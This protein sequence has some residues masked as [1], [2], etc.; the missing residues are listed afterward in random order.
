MKLSV[1]RRQGQPLVAYIILTQAECT[2]GE[3]RGCPSWRAEPSICWTNQPYQDVLVCLKAVEQL[4]FRSTSCSAVA[5]LVEV[6][7]VL[8]RR[9]GGSQLV[10]PITDAPICTGSQWRSVAWPWLN[11][12]W[13]NGGRLEADFAGRGLQA[14]R[15]RLGRYVPPVPSTACPVSGPLLQMVSGAGLTLSSPNSSSRWP[16]MPSRKSSCPSHFRFG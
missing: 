9:T 6:W 11:G 1:L 14:R 12:G 7:W 16:I 15:H 4:P 13:R 5:V 2:V 3:D 10:A 8:T